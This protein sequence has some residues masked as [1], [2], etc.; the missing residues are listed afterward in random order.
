MTR[1]APC[2]VISKHFWKIVLKILTTEIFSKIMK[3]NKI[4]Q[5]IDKNERI[6]TNLQWK[7]VKNEWY[8]Y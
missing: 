7:S 8:I 5:T 6:T 4:A 2:P 1:Q 3:K